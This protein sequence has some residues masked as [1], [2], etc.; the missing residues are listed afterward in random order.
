MGE[1][2]FTFQLR[3]S[4][5]CTVGGGF[6]CKMLFLPNIAN[7]YIFTAGKQLA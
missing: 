7:F 3:A 6:Q 1:Q 4:K 5:I 2:V